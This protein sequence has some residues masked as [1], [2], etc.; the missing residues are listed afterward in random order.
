[1]LLPPKYPDCNYFGKPWGEY[2]IS[3]DEVINKINK[4]YNTQ[5]FVDGDAFSKWLENK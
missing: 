1:M 4:D 2:G 3:R 5:G